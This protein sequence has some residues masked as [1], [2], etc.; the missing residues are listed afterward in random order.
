MKRI[1][2]ETAYNSPEKIAE[3]TEHKQKTAEEQKKDHEE[4]ENIVKK[5]GGSNASAEPTPEI[6]IQGII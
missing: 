5:Y 4:V 2:K 1:L 3:N 6:P